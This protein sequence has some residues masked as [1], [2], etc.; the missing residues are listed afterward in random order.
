MTEGEENGIIEA[1]K[2]ID[3]NKLASVRRMM[4]AG[5]DFKMI[6]AELAISELQVAGLAQDAI[7]ELIKLETALKADAKLLHDENDRL[8]MDVQ[9][10]ENLQ[11]TIRE[12]C[13]AIVPTTMQYEPPGDKK[14]RSSFCQRWGMQA[15]QHIC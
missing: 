7:R 12:S 10:L 11:T 2:S 13:V 6:A 1:I 4:G 14:T 8:R 15:P 3:R 5:Y 9:G